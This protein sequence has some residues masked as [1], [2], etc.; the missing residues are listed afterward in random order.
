[1]S[2][3]PN[4]LGG[5]RQYVT[6]DGQRIAFVARGS[7]PPM[8]LVHSIHACAWS[9][10]WRNVFESLST[11]FTVYAVDLLG[12]GASAHPPLSYTAELY[13]EQLRAFLVEVVRQPAL[14]VG[15]SLGGTYA[16]ALAARHPALVTSVCAIGP[17][18]VTRLT[19]PGGAVGGALQGLLRS[20]FP[21]L[22]LF[23]ALTSKL[24]IPRFLKDIYF[25]KRL[26]TP[27][28]V[29]LYWQAAHQPNARYAPAAFVGM[30]L[31]HDIRRALRELTC[32]L[33]LVWGEHASQTPLSESKDFLALR[34]QATIAILPGG[35]LP[36]EESPAQ[37]LV[38]LRTFAERP[39]ETTEA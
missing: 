33:L 10:E 8:V 23:S 2:E 17:A 15:S 9:M 13:L 37:F 19:T 22:A 4:P 18:G 39:R 12:F 11:T 21:G 27:E 5:T 26:L 3:L 20:G 6:L 7:G 32:P 29:D 31:N 24:S 38:A 1:M 35:D 30:R 28:V 16:I 14:L 34:P 36:H 25:D